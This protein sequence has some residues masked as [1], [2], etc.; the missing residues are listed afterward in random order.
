MAPVSPT[1]VDLSGAVHPPLAHCGRW[2]SQPDPQD[3][4]PT[5]S[6]LSART[7]IIAFVVLAGTATGQGVLESITLPSTGAAVAS[8]MTREAGVPYT[9][10]ALGSFFI[11]GR[12]DRLADAENCNFLNPSDD[13]SFDD[14]IQPDGRDV[15]RG[16][17]E[18]PH[19]D[20]I[21]HLGTGATLAVGCA[22]TLS[23]DNS[24][25]LRVEI[26]TPSPEAAGLFA[27]GSLVLGRR[28]SRFASQ[29]STPV[30][31]AGRAGTPLASVGMMAHA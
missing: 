7:A 22:G 17:Y 26:L 23:R 29:R 28:W 16:G 30:E 25:G 31:P 5:G 8:S 18:P 19:I 13:A 14:G 9:V 6:K 27:D 1:R 2:G 15:L 24:V 10:G 21:E 12:G 3:D 4:T 20:E 11:D